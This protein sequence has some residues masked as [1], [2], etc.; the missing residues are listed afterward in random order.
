MFQYVELLHKYVKEN[1]YSIAVIYEN[2]SRILVEGLVDP[3]FNVSENVLDFYY[4][5]IGEYVNH[6]PKNIK[7]KLDGHY[8]NFLALFG[9]I[10]SGLFEDGGIVLE[11]YGNLLIK[12][13]N[14]FFNDIDSFDFKHDSRIRP[15]FMRNLNQLFTIPG[16]EV[17]LIDAS[18]LY[19]LNDLSDFKYST[20]AKVNTMLSAEKLYSPFV[21]INFTHYGFNEN[22]W[23]N[24]TLNPPP[25]HATIKQEFYEC[26]YLY[27]KMMNL[28]YQRGRDYYDKVIVA[29]NRFENF[30]SP[31]KD[32]DKYQFCSVYCKWHAQFIKDWSKQDFLTLM[33]FATPQRKILLKASSPEIKLAEKL[34]GPKSIKSPNSTVAPKKPDTK[35]NLF[36]KLFGPK[37]ISSFRPSI[38]PKFLVVFCHNVDKGYY[39]DDAGLSL[40][41]CNDFFPTP[42]DLGMC[43]TRNMDIKNGLIFL[44]FLIH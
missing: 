25:V 24:N 21:K 13:L 36:E 43:L 29:K 44:S 15:I 35:M 8:A 39:G 10:V 33:K 12:Y 22:L 11:D 23:S 40:K 4:K 7:G 19:S 5:T 31:C 27:K 42:T 9:G 17:S 3:A 38:A 1:D 28:K 2:L 32:L 34:F 26:A 20:T 41:F 37:R 18:Y 6:T 30:S 14:V 16:E